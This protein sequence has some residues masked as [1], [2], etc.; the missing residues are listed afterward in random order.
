MNKIFEF[1]IRVYYA[2]TDAGGVVYHSK[3]LDF[4]EKA[5]TELLREK[6]IIQTKLKSDTGIIFVVKFLKIDYKK[7]AKLDDLLTVRTQII[8]NSGVII[9]MSQNIFN[10]NE[11]NIAQIQV[12]LV[13][14][15]KDSKPIRIP[16]N[17]CGVLC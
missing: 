1:V 4:C 12:E 17:I 8:E 7:P 13:C 11:E 2:D 9:K 5:R 3:Y 10:K 15:N 16:K 6:G 14:L